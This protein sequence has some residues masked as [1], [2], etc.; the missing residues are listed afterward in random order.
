M[1]ATESTGIAQTILRQ[2]G[3]R[4]L[5]IMTGARNFIDH[6]NA[7]SFRLP[8][9]FARNG[10][11]YVKITLDPSDTYTVEFSRI[12][13]ASVKEVSRHEDIYNDMLM[14][15]FRRETGLE[16]RMPRIQGVNA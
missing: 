9:G 1:T 15:C 3:G 6:G 14:D 5:T 4:T 13:G 11:N 16:T 12:R 8:S 7:L 10:I 2:M